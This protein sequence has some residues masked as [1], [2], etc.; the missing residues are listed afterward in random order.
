MGKNK[1]LMTSQFRISHFKFI[2]L[3]F[4]LLAGWWLLPPIIIF[5]VAIILSVVADL[6]YAIVAL[7][8]LLILMPL[9]MAF[10]YIYY[11]LQPNCWMNIL[12]KEIS[13]LQSGIELKM[14]IKRKL[15]EEESL[16]TNVDDSEETIVEDDH[17]I[18]EEK[19]DESIKY[20]IDERTRII[21]WNEIEN[22]KI[23]TDGIIL[24]I[25]GKY[26]GFLYIPISAIYNF[27]EFLDE[28]RLKI[29]CKV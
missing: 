15:A 24:G 1:E 29:K 21:E 25:S 10:L 22:I 2:L 12:D 14:F 19:V 23:S 6:T 28:L 13:F 17:S 11:G 27:S 5:I 26:K 8:T 16:P 7:M 20:E 3:L 9:V 4:R 18:S